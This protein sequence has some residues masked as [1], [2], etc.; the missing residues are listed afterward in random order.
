MPASAI[1]F[2]P[3]KPKLNELV[4]I[5]QATF[6]WE[7][8]ME[9]PRSIVRSV[10]RFLVAL[11]FLLSSSVTLSAGYTIDT[12]ASP[13]PITGL[14]WNQNESGWGMALTQQLASVSA[15][16]QRYDNVPASLADACLVRMSELY[17]PCHVLTLDS[18]FHIYRRHGRKVIPVIYPDTPGRSL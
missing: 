10:S 5:R 7:N 1:A 12:A 13:S 14:W 15:L 8:D 11:T 16:Y 3:V 2:V 4:Y 9:R 18:D 6:Q 17:E